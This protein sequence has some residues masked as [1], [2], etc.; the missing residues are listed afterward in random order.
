MTACSSRLLEDREMNS[1][2][3]FAWVKH[4]LFLIFFNE[5]KIHGYDTPLS[6]TKAKWLSWKIA[7]GYL[8]C[9]DGTKEECELNIELDLEEIGMKNGGDM[10]DS[11]KFCD[12]HYGKRWEKWWSKNEV[13][14]TTL[15]ECPACGNTVRPKDQRICVYCDTLKCPTCDMGD[16]VGCAQCDEEE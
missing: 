5:H 4:S 3:G 15:T 8:E 16:D 1:L 2:R 12:E 13:R 7:I 9:D 6:R 11:Q 14:D 10:K